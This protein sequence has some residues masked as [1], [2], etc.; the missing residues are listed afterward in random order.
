MR[1]SKHPDWPFPHRTVRYVPSP[2]D[3]HENVQRFEGDCP[4]PGEEGDTVPHTKE[5]EERP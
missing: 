5:L 2:T 3:L 1:C 4:G